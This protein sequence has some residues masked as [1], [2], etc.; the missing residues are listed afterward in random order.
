MSGD[1]RTPGPRE[2]EVANLSRE[3]VGLMQR[4]SDLVAARLDHMAQAKVN[5]LEIESLDRRLAVLRGKRAGVDLGR[6]LAEE[7]IN[8]Q[9]R[10]KAA[11]KASPSEGDE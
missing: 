1:A 6:A 10:K 4:R 2:Q 11:D 8:E 9:V 5:A 7:L 3:E